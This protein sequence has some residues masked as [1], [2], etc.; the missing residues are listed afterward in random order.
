MNNKASIKSLKAGQ[1]F[2]HAGGIVRVV[3]DA[4]VNALGE[5]IVTV[6][7]TGKPVPLRFGMGGTVE[8]IDPA[9]IPNFH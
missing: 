1:A 4:R 9:R 6:T 2:F 3:E 7:V 5:V 8:L